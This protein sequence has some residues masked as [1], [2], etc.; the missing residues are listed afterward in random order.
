MFLVNRYDL[1]GAIIDIENMYPED[2][3]LFTE[4]IRLLSETL[5]ENGKILILNMP[6]K[7]EEWP[8]RDWVGFFDYNA[9]GEY[10]DIAAIMTYEW[11]WREGP[12]RPTA[13][14]NNVRRALDYAV[15][16]NIPP[17]KILM[18]LTLYGY[19]W[20]LPDTPQNLAKAV[21]L[22]IVW[23]L[24]RKYRTSIKFDDEVKQPY[25]EYVNGN[26]IGHKVWFPNALSHYYKYGLVKEYGLR[27]V[28]YWTL[29]QP[30]TATWYILSELFEIKKV[31]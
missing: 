10:I 17:D 31:I 4:F 18:G 8:D 7:W 26:G 21:T 5:H 2:R 16:N 13:P 15:E 19:D 23:N 11:G 25:T 28:F 1:K 22:P 14:I 20:T 30:L 3:D 12:P 27:G 6:P 29:T 24:A 9:L